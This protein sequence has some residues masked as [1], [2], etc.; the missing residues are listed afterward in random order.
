MRDAREFE[1]D[2]RD[3]ERRGQISGDVRYRDIEGEI[4]F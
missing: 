4:R 2:E 1:R 3:L